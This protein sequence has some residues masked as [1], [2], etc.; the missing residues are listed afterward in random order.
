MDKLILIA[1]FLSPFRNLI[2]FSLGF[3]DLRIIQAIWT[4]VFMII[5]I[6]KAVNKQ[7]LIKD[8]V[9]SR[10]SKLLFFL[11][12]SILA[13]SCLYSINI[14]MSLKELI[15]YIYL[16]LLFAVI[17]LRAKDKVFLDKIVTT[18]VISNIILVLVCILS[19]FSGNAIIPSYIVYSNGTV[20]ANTN[21]FEINTLMENGNTI[22]RLH[23]AL[24]LGPT[25]IANIVLIQSMFVNYMIRKGK[26]LV[27]FGLIALLLCNLVTIVLTYSR[28]GILLFVFMHIFT[29]I[30]KDH[31]KNF[32]IIL[33]VACTAIAFLRVFPDVL[34]RI[35]ETFNPEQ[36]SSKYHFVFWLMSIMTGWDNILTGIGLGNMTYFT[37][38]YTYLFQQFNIN[39]AAVNPSHNFIL[40]IWSEQGAFG[41]LISIALVVKPILSYFRTYKL[42][43]RNNVYFFIL[44]A[45]ISSLICNLTNNNYYTEPFWMIFGL[46][47]SIEFKRLKTGLALK[48]YGELHA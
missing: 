22:A 30:S 12:I 36:K 48:N 8:S 23:G 33:M 46:A 24:G 27:K 42:S 37:D 26:G 7:V 11:Y 17:Y 21:L 31:V 20:V 14:N 13:I 2:I 40:Q 39:R 1:I 18:I 41:F 28:A 25:A 6:K 3:M 43:D 47:Y 44:L 9:I 4:L 15:Q 5:L 16:F 38:N 35:L 29:I 34:A 32:F 10:E 45:Y 19:Y